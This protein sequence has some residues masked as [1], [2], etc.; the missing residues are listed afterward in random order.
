MSTL[1]SSPFKNID[2]VRVAVDAPVSTDL[3][4]DIVVD[5]N[6]LYAGISNANGKSLAVFLTPGAFVWT[7]PAGITA[8]W[9][10]EVGG[11]GAGGALGFGPG[12]AGAFQMYQINGLTGAPISLQVG[13]GAVF[14]GAAATD[15]WFGAF[16]QNVAAHGGNGNNSG[17]GGTPGA[18][19]NNATTFG[20]NAPAGPFGNVYGIGGVSGVSV[21]GNGG[22]LIIHY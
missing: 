22:A 1:P 15:T 13:A 3:M 4:T 12:G 5:I 11:G 16:N 8:C 19:V 6:Y 9:I 18:V 2:S 14:G 10:E 20:L 17:G 7:P 21:N